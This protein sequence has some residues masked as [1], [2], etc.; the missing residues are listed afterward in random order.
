MWSVSI[1]RSLAPQVSSTTSALVYFCGE[2]TLAACQ[3][4]TKATLSA[5]KLLLQ[6]DKEEKIIKK[7]M[8]VEIRTGRDCSPLIVPGKADS[9]QG[10]Q[11]NLS[12]IKYG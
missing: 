3:M 5:R 12:T 1:N 7:I 2:L 8:M 4:P 11:S 6:L 10:N 9:I